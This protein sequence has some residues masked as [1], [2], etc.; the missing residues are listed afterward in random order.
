[1][2][3]EL[4]TKMT[5]PSDLLSFGSES[6]ESQRFISLGLSS[7]AGFAAPFRS[8]W[9]ECREPKAIRWVWRHFDAWIV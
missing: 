8:Q 4:H 1:V 2:T 3:Q 6:R 7:R 9:D 5:R